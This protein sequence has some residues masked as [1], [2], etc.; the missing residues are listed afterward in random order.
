MP[1]ELLTFSLGKFVKGVWIS[2]RASGLG[3]LVRMWC[4][5]SGHCY[6]NNEKIDLCVAL[7]ERRHWL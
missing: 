3:G 1:N 5:F 2:I 4:R 7:C 6:E